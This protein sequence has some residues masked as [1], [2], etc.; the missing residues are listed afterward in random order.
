MKKAFTL[1]ELLIVIAIIAI[2]AAIL[3]VSIGNQPLL[4]ARDAQRVSTLQNLRTALAVYYTNN[5]VYPASLATL[6]TDGLIPEVPVDPRDNQAGCA[7]ATYDVDG[8]A[9]VYAAGDFGYFYILGTTPQSYLLASCLEDPT[10]NALD[11]DCDT[12]TN[13]ACFADPVYDVHS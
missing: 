4:R 3:F 2:L 13:P 7:L 6:Q 10:S 12:G 11:S 9:A 5:D 8:A 1:I